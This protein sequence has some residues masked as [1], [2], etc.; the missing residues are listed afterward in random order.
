MFLL[1]KNKGLWAYFLELFSF[2]I[3]DKAFWF[4]LLILINN[5]RNLF[6]IYINVD[7]DKMLL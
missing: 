4:L 7:N 5:L 2:V 3:L 6:I 1:E